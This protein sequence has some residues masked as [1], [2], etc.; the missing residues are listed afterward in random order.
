MARIEIVT[1]PVA[2]IEDALESGLVSLTEAIA[3]IDPGAVA[4]GCLGGEFGYGAEWSNDVFEMHPFDWEPECD[5]GA[6]PEI[7]RR[8]DAM[9]PPR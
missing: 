7:S 9:H 4:H 8:L 2:R 1:P 3:K 5:C 6:G